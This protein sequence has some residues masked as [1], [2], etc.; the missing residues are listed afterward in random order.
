[1][2]LVSQ[3]C[4]WNQ[5]LL[6]ANHLPCNAGNFGKPVF[7]FCAQV[8]TSGCNVFWWDAF[9][10]AH[11]NTL[12]LLRI[13]SL[14]KA[15][16]VHIRAWLVMP[17]CLK[18][19]TCSAGCL[20]RKPAR[21]PRVPSGL[22]CTTGLFVLALFI[23]SPDSKSC[24][25]DL[26]ITTFKKP[27]NISLPQISLTMAL[28]FWK[29]HVD[30]QE[31]KHKNT[32][33]QTIVVSWIYYLMWHTSRYHLTSFLKCVPLSIKQTFRPI[34]TFTVVTILTSMYEDRFK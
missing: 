27:H 3:S 26:P 10:Q 5:T 15:L 1:M 17:K 6:I 30:S 18:C 11:T 20:W 7:A 34:L 33:F 23:F 2:T 14:K 16:C 24:D 29:K 25:S 12:Q 22:V 28:I 21:M 13:C 9:K 32:I 8:A 19:S 31:Y 4:M